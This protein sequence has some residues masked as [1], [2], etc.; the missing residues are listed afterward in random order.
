MFFTEHRIGSH[1]RSVNLALLI[2][3]LNTEF[4][5]SLAERRDRQGTTVVLPEGP[6]LR[7]H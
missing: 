2:H 5:N 6:D 1:R 3:A 7:E 4:R